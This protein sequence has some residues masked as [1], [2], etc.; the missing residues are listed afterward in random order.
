MNDI[1][2]DHSHQHILYFTL[3][4]KKPE[5]YKWP[6]QKKTAC[7]Q[8]KPPL[9]ACSQRR[10]YITWFATL[11]FFSTAFK[12]HTPF[13]QTQSLAFKCFSVKTDI[14]GFSFSDWIGSSLKIKNL[15]CWVVVVVNSSNLKQN[16]NYLAN[17]NKSTFI[18]TLIRS[19]RWG[20]FGAQ[21]G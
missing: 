18:I 9:V 2:A 16:K 7:K 3:I 4:S 8:N 12:S 17:S 1:V 15:L 21:T 13:Q 19:W 10:R 6:E 20:K 5:P 11:F 14:S